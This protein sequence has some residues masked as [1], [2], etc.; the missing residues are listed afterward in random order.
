MQI[1]FIEG[2]GTLNCSNDLLYGVPVL[3]ACIIAAYKM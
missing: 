1:Y 3:F 2:D